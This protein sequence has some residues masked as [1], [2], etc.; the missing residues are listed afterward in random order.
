MRSKLEY[1]RSA[2]LRI[3]CAVFTLQFLYALV[4]TAG[5]TGVEVLLALSKLSL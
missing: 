3:K 4:L 2:A 5:M 1:R